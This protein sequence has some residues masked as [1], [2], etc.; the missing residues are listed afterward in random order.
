MLARSLCVLALAVVLAPSMAA[1]QLKIGY[2]VTLSGPAAQLGIDSVDAFKLA[3]QKL[4]GKLGGVAVELVVVDDQLKPEIGVEQVKRLLEK[5]QTPIIVGTTFS[6]VLMAIAQ[7]ATRAGAFLISPNAGPSPLAG[8]QCNPNFF[9]VAFQNDQIYEPIGAYLQKKGTKR[10][11]ALA[12]NYQAGKDAIAGFKATFKGEI[13]D[14]IYTPLAQLDF[15]GALAR[16]ASLRPDAVFAFYPGGLAVSFVKQYDQAGVNKNIPLYGGFPLV[17]A[18]VRGAQGKA[19]IGLVTSGNWQEDLANATNKEF[20]EAYRKAHNREP[21]EF[22]AYAHDTAMLLNGALAAVSGN[23]DNKDALR[24]ALRE[25]KFASVRG[26]FRFNKNQFPI[27]DWYIRTVVAD[28]AGTKIVTGEKIS[29][30]AE[31]RFAAQ[32]TMK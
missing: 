7:P 29:P 5:E 26:T 9:A 22:A 28:G 17:D 10:V 18:T 2:M 15:S 20:T 6:N 19:A 23:V 4:N 31:D 1:A 8:A 14:E 12:P 24:A 21:S 11:V 25:A 16:I 32:C 27:Q 3:L 30:A 13:V